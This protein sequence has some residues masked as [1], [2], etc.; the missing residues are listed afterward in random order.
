M[1]TPPPHSP[2][3]S[4]QPPA[5]TSSC[6][7]DEQ[8]FAAVLSDA[9]LNRAETDLLTG[10]GA[11]EAALASADFWTRHAQHPAPAE[12]A[13]DE[14]AGVDTDLWIELGTADH[15]PLLK[16]RGG[17]DAP[18]LVASLPADCDNAA[19]LSSA[20]AQVWAHGA[21]ID[22][23]LVNGSRPARPPKLPTY[24][25]DRRY[26]W[27]EEP[28]RSADAPRTRGVALQPMVLSAAT[29]ETLA[30]T[31]LSLAALPFLGEHRV[32]GHLVVP[33]VVFLELI[34]RTAESAFHAPAHVEDLVLARPLVLGDRDTA[35]VQVVVS[36]PEDGRAKVRVFTKDAGDDWQQHLS[37][38]VAT[39]VETDEFEE[40]VDPET[41]ARA[42]NRID[43][44]IDDEEF[45]EKAWHP[46]FHLGPSFRLIRDPSR[47]KQVGAGT[48]VL[49]ADDASGITS[50][51][52]PE[53][54]VLDAC[55]QL[56]T[57][58][59]H[60][61]V[62]Q[63]WEDRPVRLGTGYESMV[64][65]RPI[66]GDRMEC[67][68][69]LRETGE[70]HLIGDLVLVAADGMPIAE[71]AGV[72]FRPVSPEI[73][74]RAV[75]EQA[76]AEAQV[77]HR[78]T[79]PVVD[80]AALRAAE[81]AERGETVLD[82][83][84]SLFADILGMRQEE[85]DIDTGIVELADSLMMAELKARVERDLAVTLPM[86][87]LFDGSGLKSIARW[88]SSE[89]ADVVPTVSAEP[90]P[91]SAVTADA[92]AS[93][94]SPAAAPASSLAVPTRLR[95]MSVEEMTAEAELDTDITADREPDAAAPETTLLTGGTGFVG[96][97]LLAELLRRRNGN[98]IC[99]VRAEDEEHA[100][101][102][103][104][105]NLEA[106]G[107]D[108]GS[109]TSRIVPVIGDLA[110]P[111]FGLDE[112]SFAALHDRV[113]DIV[114]CGGVVKWTYPYKGLEPANV[115]GTREVLRLATTGAPRP[116]HF[117]STVGV[118]SSEEFTADVV[119]EEQ[120]LHTSGPLVVGYAQ[121]KWVA[122]KMVRTAHSRGVPM[123]IHRI[124]TG[125]HSVSGAFNEL[126]H[127]NMI[128]K[129]CIEAGIAPDD[130]PM[131]VQPAPIDYVAA[132]VVEAS[133]RP[134]LDGSTLHLVNDT[135]ME[136]PELFDAVE[137]FGYPLQRLSFAEWKERVT[138]RSSG[139]MALLGL[140]PFL[141][142][143]VD[144]VRLPFSDAEATRAALANTGL[145]CPP[146]NDDLIHTYLRQYVATGFVEAP[147][148]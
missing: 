31:E 41:I 60:S 78:A 1:P 80:L 26:Y 116:V 50:G 61:G 22:W 20:L 111:L 45:Y 13:L 72:S 103:V 101:R 120:P 129:G 18:P 107:L 113:G 105:S 36:R 99:V 138:S 66:T 109:E 68:A 43:E 132:A 15:L 42:Q 11:A 7:T 122:E 86:E 59:A 30:E 38:V 17:E 67:T 34:L 5:P 9:Q 100:L 76:T 143:T 128:L 79:P 139:T 136:W 47:G 147:A 14:A 148:R 44:Y 57:A 52:R 55:I 25:F 145:S 10:H 126:D 4:P 64:L 114:H 51:V 27:R 115:S 85:L 21:D 35:V 83:L 141:N 2:A 89:I 54:L 75:D 94:A 117:I 73:L 74:R 48:L 37:A 70:G 96:A 97:F 135:A 118:F 108:V 28:A 71:I 16:N 144:H 81:G 23:T 63:G 24:R 140:A 62:E 77:A 88:V 6:A 65:H 49:P 93:T 90:E 39:A 12:A 134:E 19:G 46:D 125:G 102:R 32:H 106:Y 58:A 91:V 3:S 40:L 110:E 119:A 121:S 69:A 104:V 146:L 142:D 123:T 98:V 130:G 87:M 95:W 53:L 133:C 29:G 92:A 112:E 127:L 82:H 8:Q 84:I 33:G 131:P 124:N 56:V 137:K